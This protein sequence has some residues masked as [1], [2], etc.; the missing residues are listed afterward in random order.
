MPAKNTNPQSTSKKKTTRAKKPPVIDQQETIILADALAVDKSTKINRKTLFDILENEKN[1]RL[2]YM[3]VPRKVASLLKSIARWK[4]KKDGHENDQNE[5]GEIISVK[6]VSKYYVIG[7]VITKVLDNI[8]LS[9][10]KGEFVLLLGVSGGGKSTLLNLISGLDRV[11]KGQIIINN[12]TL[13]YMS[14]REITNLRR[15]DISFIFQNYN[16][17]ENLNAFDNVMTG[18]FLQKDP[19]RKVDVNALFNEFDMQEEI[20]KFPSQLSGGQQQR[21]SI[22]R[23]L[24]KNAKIIFA[25]EPTGALDEGTTRVVLNALWNVN[26]KLGTTVVMVSHNP[27]MQPMASKTVLVQKGKIAKIIINEKPT[28]P[29]KLGLYPLDEK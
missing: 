15:R 23:A 24:A 11:S 29:D 12:H 19:E 2:K 27:A 25:D 28:E 20:Q 1:K 16:L 13:P 6:N 26:K 14:D 3:T 21:I 7:N 4:R 8:H 10:N 18:A 17:L 5:L 22:M 9:I